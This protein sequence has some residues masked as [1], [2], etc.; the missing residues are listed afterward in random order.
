MLGTQPAREQIRGLHVTMHKAQAVRF[1]QRETRLL[2]QV[3]RPFRRERAVTLHHPLQIHPAQ[4]FHHVIEASRL[5]HAE[6]VQLHGVRRLQFGRGVRFPLE[7]LSQR[8]RISRSLR[9]SFAES[10]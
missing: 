3:D 4:P 6:I 7:A 8:A 10:A 5:G 1:R 9:L 2:Q